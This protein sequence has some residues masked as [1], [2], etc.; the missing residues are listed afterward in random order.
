MNIETAKTFSFQ[1]DMKTFYEEHGFIS[2]KNCIPLGALS[3]IK[4]DLD[5]L[6]GGYDA[7]CFKLATEDKPKLYELHKA[8]NLLV[9][10][11]SLASLFGETVIALGNEKPVIEISS[12]I[13]LGLPKDT[14]LTYDFHQE[15]NFMKGF[16]D[17]LNVH[18]PIFRQ[19]N[20]EN[21][22]MSGLDK[23]HKLGTLAFQ[24]SRISEDSYTN[25][26]PTDIES[27]APQFKE[28]HFQL[29]IGDCLF[30]HKDFIH[31]SNF[32]NSELCRPVGISRMTQD[33]SGDFNPRSPDEL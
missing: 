28:V 21:G 24:K 3:L 25:L 7:A 8:A 1:S 5:D 13:L 15:S 31:K 30:F 14:R 11:R 17:I 16:G 4:N 10:I 26:I 20:T 23:S 2:I 22:T 18:Y 9:S 29:D 12:G 32:N 19:S 27:V 6:F 33:A